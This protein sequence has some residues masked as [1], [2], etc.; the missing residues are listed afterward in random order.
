MSIVQR[1]DFLGKLTDNMT[2][3]ILHF[4]L[5][6]LDRTVVGVSVR[7]SVWSLQSYSLLLVIFNVNGSAKGL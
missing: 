2:D 3:C 7:L 5:S 4:P 6:R 1:E